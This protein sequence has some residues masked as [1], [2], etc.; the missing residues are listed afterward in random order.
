M[1]V[2]T[3]GTTSPRW[4]AGVH[5]LVLAQETVTAKLVCNRKASLPVAPPPTNG[6]SVT[7]RRWAQLERFTIWFR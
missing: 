3:F 5:R 7:V 2:R 1:G 6:L 4:L